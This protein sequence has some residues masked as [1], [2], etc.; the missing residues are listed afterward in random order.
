MQVTNFSLITLEFMIPLLEYAYSLGY[1]SQPD[2]TFILDSFKVLITGI[3]K[4]T[5]N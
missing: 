4:R 3:P 1:E 2:Y 5:E